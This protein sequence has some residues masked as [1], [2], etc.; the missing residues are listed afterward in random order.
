[1]VSLLSLLPV[2]LTAYFINSFI[3]VL[4]D[5]EAIMHNIRLREFLIYRIDIGFSHIQCYSLNS[6]LL[7]FA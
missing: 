3:K 7:F 1:M 5:M 4:S 6:L 2:L